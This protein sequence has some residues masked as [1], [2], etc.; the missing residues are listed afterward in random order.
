MFG[1]S[2]RLEELEARIKRLEGKVERSEKEIY[3]LRRQN[4]I[5]IYSRIRFPID[6]Y[7][8]P[9]EFDVRDVVDKILDHLNLGITLHPAQPEF[10]SLEPINNDDKSE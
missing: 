3:E 6:M 5:L 8:A 1:T 10:F 7:K 9:H 2:K 4:K